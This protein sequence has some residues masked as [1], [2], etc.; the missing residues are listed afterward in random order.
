M[1]KYNPVC[2]EGGKVIT[3][4][5]FE[6][7]LFQTALKERKDEL[8]LQKNGGKKNGGRKREK[9]SQSVSRS[10]GEFRDISIDI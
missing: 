5:E 4:D 1:A 10:I 3:K 9:V 7:A 2:L 8:K 6:E